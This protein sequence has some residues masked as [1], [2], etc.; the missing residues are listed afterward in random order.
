MLFYFFLSVS[1]ILFHALWRFFLKNLSNFLFSVSEFWSSAHLLS[2]PTSSDQTGGELALHIFCG[3][4]LWI[5]RSHLCGCVQICVCFKTWRWKTD[6]GNSAVQSTRS[7]R[8]W[9][10]RCFSFFLRPA[11]RRKPVSKSVLNILEDVQLCRWLSCQSCCSSI[12]LNP[13]ESLTRPVA[14][15]SFV[16]SWL[17]FRVR[18]HFGSLRVYSG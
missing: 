13:R 10:A 18:T 17:F 16:S 4:K 14:H 3:G 5:I 12:S 2:L 7:H 8:S 6:G 1:L 9:L 15:F 11:A